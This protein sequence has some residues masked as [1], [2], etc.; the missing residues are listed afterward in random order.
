MVYGSCKIVQST[1]QDRFINQ[2]G[3]DLIHKE[4]GID[5]QFVRMICCIKIIVLFLIISCLQPISIMAGDDPQWS[6]PNNL[7][8]WLYSTGGLV[9]EQN[10]NGTVAVVWHELDGIP[11]TSFALMVKVR[12]PSGSWGSTENVTG[13][14]PLP[15]SI[16]SFQVRVA[17][18]DTVWFAMVTD[19][20]SYSL[21]KVYQRKNTNS[22]Q[23]LILSAPMS[24]IRGMDFHI[25][26]DGDIGLIWVGCD[27]GTDYTKGSCQTLA[28]RRA[29]ES[30]FWTSIEPLET[31]SNGLALP[32]IRVGPNGMM[33][34]TWVKFESA[35]NWRV[36]GKFCPSPTAL[37]QSGV[38]NVSN[39]VEPFFADESWV[40]APVMGADGTFVIAWLHK[41]GANYVMKS[42]TRSAVTSLWSAEARISSEHP[43]V[44]MEIPRLAVGQDGTVTAVWTR[45]DNGTG[46]YAAF[47]NVRDAGGIW[48]P[49]ETQLSAWMTYAGIEDLVVLPDGRSVVIWKERDNTKL[50][51]DEAAYWAHRVKS[52]GWISGQVSSWN[53]GVYGAALAGIQNDGVYVVWAEN[54]SSLPQNE[55]YTILNTGCSFS[56][57]VCSPPMVLAGGY[58]Y[59]ALYDGSVD[60]TM[61]KPSASVSWF[62]SR[63]SNNP[64]YSSESAIFFS[65]WPKPFPWTLFIPVITKAGR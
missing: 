62:G 57:H 34:A 6:F 28:R 61:I 21:V 45:V 1:D 38:S 30:Q 3:Y 42:S 44:G 16:N 55:T 39:S 41:T 24:K 5:M 37:W 2:R 31:S 60:F 15:S 54:N 23:Q 52:G 49:T 63:N 32:S 65:Q 7:S 8:G 51:K 47:A 58:K 9:L 46:K 10:N 12:S 27:D 14:I 13:F 48:A 33:I 19:E 17:P 29:A 36:L 43:T 56:S 40:S 25:G 59:A 50:P 22:W 53:N 35:P 64:L 11:A 4:G 26:P 20:G 18:D